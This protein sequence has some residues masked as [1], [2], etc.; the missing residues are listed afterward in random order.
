[1]SPLTKKPATNGHQIEHKVQRLCAIKPDI[2]WESSEWEAEN[3]WRRTRVP[4]LC[5]DEM[6]FFS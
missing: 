6:R 1:M 2:F 5:T 3:V 4:T